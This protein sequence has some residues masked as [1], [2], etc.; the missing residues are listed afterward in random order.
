MISVPSRGARKTN[1]S[2][3]SIGVRR[4][5]TADRQTRSVRQ[6]R[7]AAL[8]ARQG[9]PGGVRRAAPNHPSRGTTQILITS[10]RYMSFIM[11][12]EAIFWQIPEAP[13]LLTP[14]LLSLRTR[15][16]RRLTYAMKLTRTKVTADSCCDS[17]TCPRRLPKVKL[18]GAQCGRV[19]GYTRGWHQ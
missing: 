19:S 14:H 12:H 5:R 7:T 15:V 16:M 8:I 18:D 2:D 9:D 11:F 10:I 4:F 13:A 1:M 3:P 6:R 17:A